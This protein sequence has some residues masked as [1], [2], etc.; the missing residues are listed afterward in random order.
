MVDVHLLTGDD[1]EFVGDQR[2]DQVPGQRRVAG[3]WRQDVQS[4]PLV[5]VLIDVRGPDGKRRHLIEEE[6]QAMVVV[7]DHGDV[8][9]GLS[10]PLAHGPV[11][12]EE[13]LPV[14]VLF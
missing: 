2:F 11:S 8:R 6:I 3:D 9:L 1:I 10:Q 13:R 7:D 12:V 14:R 5:T 4:P